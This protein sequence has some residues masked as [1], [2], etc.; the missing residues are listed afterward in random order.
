[1]KYYLLPLAAAMFLFASCKNAA[2]EEEI[3]EEPK[4]VEPAVLP[5]TTFASVEELDYDVEIVDTTMTGLLK[6]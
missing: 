1:M 2:P 6:L 5:D 3:L 4:I